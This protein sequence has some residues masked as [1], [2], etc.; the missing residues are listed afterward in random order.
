MLCRKDT[1]TTPGQMT[2][3]GPSRAR[4][5]WSGWLTFPVQV[6][7]TADADF[8][9]ARRAHSEIDGWDEEPL[10]RSTRTFRRP[11]VPR[12]HP[13]ATTRRARASN[14]TCLLI[15]NYPARCAPE[16]SASWREALHKAQGARRSSLPLLRVPTSLK[17]QGLHRSVWPHPS[18]SS[19]GDR[20]IAQPLIF[21]T[22]TCRNERRRLKAWCVLK[23]AFFSRVKVRPGKRQCAR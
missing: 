3:F 14:R 5:P 15:V 18:V 10:R 11:L 16:T 17:C 21:A 2:L 7:S 1:L 4:L 9:D 13:E 8:A 19:S 12:T 23:D 22:R 6:W 20:Q